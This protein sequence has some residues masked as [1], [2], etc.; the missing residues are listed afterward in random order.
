MKKLS[1]L[2]VLLIFAVNLHSQS[3]IRRAIPTMGIALLS[4]M[5]DGVSQDL[6][7]HYD[8]FKNTFPNANDKYWDPRLSWRNKWKNGN[9]ANGEAFWGSSTFLVWTTDGYHLM[10]TTSRM[11]MYSSF[12]INGFRSKNWKEII[13]G[14]LLHSVIWSIGFH[15]TYSIVIK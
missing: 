5:S 10:R 4:G 14:T 1:L 11:T 9:P 7:W 2:V 12:V 8:E 6:I 13:L 3:Y 15:I